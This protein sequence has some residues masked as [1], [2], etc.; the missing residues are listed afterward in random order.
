MPCVALLAPYCSF[1]SNHGS[2]Y[3]NQLAALKLIV[4]DVAGA[5]NVTNTYFS[6]IYLGQVE[7]NGEQVSIIPIEE[8]RWPKLFCSLSKLL[9]P[10][11]SII[12]VII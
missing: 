11:P 8:E 5:T 7:A 3:Y 4:N 12:A 9:E 1:D 6:G 2:Y 10:D